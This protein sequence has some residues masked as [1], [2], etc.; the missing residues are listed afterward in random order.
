MV[1]FGSSCPAWL[2]GLY[3]CYL[4]TP[5]ISRQR[6]RWR[7]YSSL[8]LFGLLLIARWMFPSIDNRFVFDVLF[9][10]VGVVTAPGFDWKFNI[11]YGSFVKSGIIL[12]FLFLVA[13]V[14][15]YTSFLY[16]PLFQMVL[17]AAGVFVILFVCE[18]LSKSLFAGQDSKANGSFV[19]KVVGFVSYASMACYMFHRFFYWGAE[20][21]WNP[22]DASVKWLYMAAVVYPVIVVSSY[23]IQKLY[24]AFAKRF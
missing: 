3:R 10:F 11:P 4:V 23:A 24:D 20:K 18:A 15:I 1:D 8:T 17:G 12:V 13:F 14:S 19:C 2:F 5:L 6:L 22:S 21:I 7:V 16:H 9:Y